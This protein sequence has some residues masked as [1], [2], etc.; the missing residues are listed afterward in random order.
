MIGQAGIQRAR[1]DI[2]GDNARTAPHLARHVA[3]ILGQGCI[4]MNMGAPS[5]KMKQCGR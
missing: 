4:G 5:M 1:V 2:F 3:R